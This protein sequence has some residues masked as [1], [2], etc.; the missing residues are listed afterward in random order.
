M[1]AHP[2][3]HNDLHRFILFQI[4]PQFLNVHIQVPGVE[5]RIVPPYPFEDVA[6]LHGE[7]PVFA[8]SGAILERPNTKLQLLK[9]GGYLPNLG[10]VFNNTNWTLD[11]PTVTADTSEATDGVNRKAEGEKWAF[12]A[13]SGTIPT[14]DFRLRT[15]DFTSKVQ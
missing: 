12:A 2:L 14:S 1:A 4:V 3:Q 6:A 10:Y 8:H 13:Y 15:S 5:E 9:L 7:L 11:G